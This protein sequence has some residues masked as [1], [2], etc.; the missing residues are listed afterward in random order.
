MTQKVIKTKQPEYL[1]ID[2]NKFKQQNKSIVIVNE[3]RFYDRIDET[4]TCIISFYS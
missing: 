1:V 3:V 4:Q 2:I